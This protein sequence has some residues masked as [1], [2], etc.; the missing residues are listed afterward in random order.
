LRAQLVSIPTDGKP[1]DGAFYEPDSGPTR[2]AVLLMHG[3]VGN[4]YT[5][6]SRFLPER[7]TSVG[8]ACLAFNRRGHDI[9]VNEAGRGVSGG[10]FQTA[11]E[12]MQDN[13]HGAAFLAQQ[14]YSAPVVIGHS[15]GGMLAGCFAADRPEVSGLVLLSAHAG[16]SN[17]YPRSC[18]SGLMAAAR[19]HEFAEKARSLVAE[20]RGDELILLPSWWYAITAASLVDRMDNTPDLL[21]RASSVTCP[22][23]AIRGSTESPVTYPMEEF[24]RRAAGPSEAHIVEGSDHWYTGYESV[25]TDLVAE[26]LVSRLTVDGD[27]GRVGTTKP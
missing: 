23:L 13:E 9:L 11:A 4:F 16:G 20:G 1:L 6:P 17:T 2:G 24:A 7:L 12:G 10:A 26:W 22:S 18:A 15:N 3:N 27:A 14:G 21:A 19:A 8:F 25:V 5:G